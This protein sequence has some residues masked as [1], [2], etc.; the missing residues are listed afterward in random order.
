V[1]FLSRKW[2]NL[3]VAI[4]LTYCCTMRWSSRKV[5]YTSGSI[6]FPDKSYNSFVVSVESL[7]TLD[8]FNLYPYIINN[9]TENLRTV[10]K[11]KKTTNTVRKTNL[12]K[13]APCCN[14]TNRFFPAGT[15]CWMIVEWTLNQRLNQNSTLIQRFF[16]RSVPGGVCSYT[17]VR[18]I[19]YHENMWILNL[20][21]INS[22][23]VSKLLN[24]L[25][26]NNGHSWIIINSIAILGALTVQLC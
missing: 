3:H 4:L 10:C 12:F 18:C 1:R 5:V 11:K 26:N 14:Y 9:K 15:L 8:K 23:N 22:V 16:Q 7:A 2:V 24:M 17:D 20:Q 19:P 6:K 21:E 25:F 13:T